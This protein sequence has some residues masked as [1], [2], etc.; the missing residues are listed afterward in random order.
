MSFGIF[1]C[2]YCYSLLVYVVIDD[3]DPKSPDHSLPGTLSDGADSDDMLDSAD[4]L[5]R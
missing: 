4:A 1:C 5:W 3:V 2:A